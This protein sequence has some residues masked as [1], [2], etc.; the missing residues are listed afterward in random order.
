MIE[1]PKT[2]QM[3]NLDKFINEQYFKI[4][5]YARPTQ[6]NLTNNCIVER[7]GRYIGNVDKIGR[8]YVKVYTYVLGKRVNVTIDLRTVTFIEE[9]A[10]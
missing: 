6:Y 8:V 10:I 7:V 1:T 2:T 3:I 9:I 4:D 5:D